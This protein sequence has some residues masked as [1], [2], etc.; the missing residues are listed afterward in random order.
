VK[1]ENI[2]FYS[3]NRAKPINTLYGQNVES[4]NAEVC[5]TYGNHSALK[6]Y[7]LAILN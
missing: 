2:A 7:N 6:G 3:E 5:V 4:L 1:G